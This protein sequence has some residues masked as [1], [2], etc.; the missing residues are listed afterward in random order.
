VTTKSAADDAFAGK[1]VDAIR[2]H[3]F[4]DRPRK[5]R[6]SGTPPDDTRGRVVPESE[7]R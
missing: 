4:W 7:M 1:F 2:Q 6:V 3:R 5:N